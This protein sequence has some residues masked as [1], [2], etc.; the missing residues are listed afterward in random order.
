MTSKNMEEN[1]RINQMIKY[2][3]N[4]YQETFQLDT[5]CEGQP[6]GAYTMILVKSKTFPEGEIIIRSDWNQK[7]EWVQRDNYV[8]YYLQEQVREQIQII[9]AYVYGQCKVYYKPTSM[10]LPA[11]YSKEMGVEEFL[12][13]K[14]SMVHIYIYLP[15]QASIREKSEKAELLQEELIRKGYQLKGLICYI[16]NAGFYDYISDANYREAYTEQKQT[17]AR[18]T[19]LLEKAGYTYLRW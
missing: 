16:N 17:C 5:V 14:E 1:N 2:A 4:K 3:N 8:S 19:F 7:G 12:S 6:G 9:A 15:T 13:R 10:V 18:G 11:E